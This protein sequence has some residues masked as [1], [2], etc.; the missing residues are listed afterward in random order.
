M[1]FS[2][3]KMNNGENLIYWGNFSF[4]TCEKEYYSSKNVERKLKK[5]PK[6]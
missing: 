5:F 4:G 1:S 2:I 6:E 3:E